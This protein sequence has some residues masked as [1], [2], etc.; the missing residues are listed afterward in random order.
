MKKIFKRLF[1]TILAMVMLA[2]M[3]PNGVFKATAIGAVAQTEYVTGDIIEYGSYPQSKVTDEN[4]ITALNAQPLQSDSTVTY[5]GAKYKRVY[6]SQYTDRFGD[7][8]TDPYLT[9][10][11]D[12]GYYINTVY[13]FK[14]EP[15]QWRVLSNTNGELFVMAEKIL[16]SR[17]Y[18]QVYTSVTWETC[19]MRSWLNNDFYNTAFNV[20]EQ[21]KIK[22]STVV[23]EDN[24]WYG[25]DGGNNTSDKLF[26]LSYCEVM[27]PAYGF[28]SDQYN[29]DT[30]RRS[31]ASDFAKSN[32]LWFYTDSSYLGN[33][34]WWLRSPGYYPEAAGN[35]EYDGPVSGGDAGVTS[36][37]YGARPAMNLNLTSDISTS[38]E[39]D[40]DNYTQFVDSYF[41]VTA[42]FSS[43]T[44]AFNSSTISYAFSDPSA[45][46]V[47]G[48]MS[49]V[50][51]ASNGIVSIMVEGIKAGTYTVTFSTSDG[52]SSTREII[53]KEDE[54]QLKVYTQYENF[55]VPVG[56]NISFGVALYL[57]GNLV[58]NVDSYLFVFDNASIFSITNTIPRDI[59][60]G[61]FLKA[62]KEGST[63][64]NIKEV[65]SGAYINL[66]F[67]ATPEENVYRFNNVPEKQY[68]K[69]TTTNFYSV[70]GLFVDHFTY[71]QNPD[72]SYTVS[73]NIYN[74]KNVYG[75]VTA[76]SEDGIIQDYAVIEKFDSYMQS[77]RDFLEQCWYLPG[78]IGS[79]SDP[80]SYTNGNLSEKTEIT[81]KVPKNG[82]IQI[83]NN[84]AESMV[85][86]LYNVI[87]FAVSGTFTAAGIMSTA[88]G[89]NNLD[90]VTDA[91]V[92]ETVNEMLA[93]C[94][95]DALVAL[96]LELGQQMTKGITYNQI[97][98]II[99]ATKGILVSNSIDLSAIIVD[100]SADVGISVAEA[101]FTSFLSIPGQVLDSLFALNKGISHLDFSINFVNSKE[102][103]SINVYTPLNDSS[104]VSNGIIVTPQS[105]N[106]EDN[107]ILHSYAITNG[108]EINLNTGS[109]EDVVEDYKIYNITMYK[110]GY[111]TQPNQKVRVMIPI[112]EGYDRNNI[113]VYRY[114]DDGT[115]GV[116][117][118]TIEGNFAVF[119][120][121]HLSYYI[122]ADMAP[123]VNITQG[124]TA[125]PDKLEIKVPWYR[126]YK[127]SKNDIQLGFSTNMGTDVTAVWSSDNPSKV[128][129]DQTGKIKN[130]KTGART[131]N[132]TVNLVDRE[133]NV[134]ATDSL[135]VIFYKYNWQLK[136]LQTQSFVSDNYA[137]R[138]MS[139]QEFEESGEAEPAISINST[140]QM[141]KIVDMITYIISLL[142]KIAIK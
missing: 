76:Y 105:G 51:T 32:G 130:L 35:V 122:I 37:Y 54:Y 116:M 36:T 29:H 77:L 93:N 62:V 80:Y 126:S 69:D 26:L 44:L 70:G 43:S 10:Q 98:Q 11:D 21:A 137:Q 114:N 15:I 104:Q 133:N 141:Q 119:E 128:Q 38:I 106:F 113:S 125:L 2:S 129:V 139:A 5:G 131:A 83:S 112:P 7:T 110:N 89:L 121:S 45:F 115:L 68:A 78:Q 40:V 72:G 63:F 79:L 18:N 42:D 48:S 47:S 19:T 4:I 58:N 30:A 123:S 67:T 9:Y 111:E 142:R 74:S 60:V 24:P 66:V 3:V 132:I 53:I 1:G 120:T 73:M 59:G 46:T 14:Y 65:N 127:N 55:S 17:A 136:K 49:F 28:S 124:S 82:Y 50:G 13:W 96:S 92:K 87:N 140:E 97:D 81:V 56:E 33:S 84:S 12:N 102:N 31:Q 85:A 90:K 91:V 25:N 16:A 134:I 101:A 135:K 34:Y 88:L 20:T 138:N 95:E 57:N 75:A 41:S 94:T 107:V 6:F 86:Y 100:C 61:V 108:N 64:L 118:V 99:A 8:S 23:N 103:E 71:M 109:F 117:F 22:T 27:N 39:I 52:A